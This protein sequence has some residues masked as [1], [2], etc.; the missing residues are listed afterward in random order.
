[1][2]KITLKL[3]SESFEI[4][5]LK[6]T[7]FEINNELKDYWVTFKPNSVASIRKGF[8]RLSGIKDQNENNATKYLILNNPFIIYSENEIELRY[9]GKLEFYVHEKMNKK[10]L[11]DKN[12][13][14]IHKKQQLQLIQS[15]EAN[16]IYFFDTLEML[17]LR[18]EVFYETALLNFELVKECK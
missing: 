11:K 10:T 7:K 2:S 8:F 1:M 16:N 13:Q 18:E 17:K 3:V 9:K 6:I 4:K 15:Y 14:L 5:K 12:S